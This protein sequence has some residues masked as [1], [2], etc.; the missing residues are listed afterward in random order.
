MRTRQLKEERIDSYFG[1]V[2]RNES[3]KLPNHKQRMLDNFKRLHEASKPVSSCACGIC[4]PNSEFDWDEL[5]ESLV[6]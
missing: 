3:Q 1:G 2:V 6:K 4:V 5:A